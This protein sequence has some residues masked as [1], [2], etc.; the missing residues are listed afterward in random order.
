MKL[1]QTYLITTIYFL[2]FITQLSAQDN[3]E[4]QQKDTS[5]IKEGWKMGIPIPIISFDQ[6]LGFQY[7]LGIDLFDY[8][9]PGIYPEYKHKFYVEWSRTTKGSGIN[10]IYYDSEYLIPNIRLTADVSYLTE[11][12]LQFFGFNG[13]DAIY[14]ATWEDDSD[15]EYKSRVFYRH[16]RKIFRILAN[17]QGNL[18]KS[19]D[20]L[21]WIAG[22]AYFDNKT[23]PVDIDRLNKGKDEEEKLPDIDG[24][25]DKY[26]D[27]EII[28][29]EEAKGNKTTYLKVGLVYDSR[30]FEFFPAKGIWSEATFSYAP[31]FLGDGKFS[32]SKLTL[33]HRH[34]LSLGSKDLIFAYRLG[35]QATLSGTVP[36]HMQPHI[37][38]TFM[39]AATSQGLGGAKTLRGIMRNRVVGDGIALG[40]VELRWKFLKIQMGKNSLYLGTNLFFDVGRVMNKI[41]IDYDKLKNNQSIFGDDQ[42]EDYFDPGAEDFHFS[43]GLGLKIGYNENQII[44]VDYG[45]AMDDRDGKSGLYIRF[46]WMF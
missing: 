34:Y 29:P 41:H 38:P 8:G 45:V 14:N 30:D 9:K 37:V 40:N 18:L 43:A 7:G 4:E 20:K 12:A 24:L 32:Y 31:E 21:K 28:K 35:Y 39:T 1:P 3:I 17:F 16:D 42:F 27:W 10:R 22:F 33:I 36:F 26:V 19:N 44:S 11:Q 5:K 2:L 23:G 15:P 46:F 25:Y 13:Y 6:D